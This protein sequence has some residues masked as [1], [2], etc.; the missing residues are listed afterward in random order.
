MQMVISIPAMLITQIIIA[1][2]LQLP[3]EYNFVLFALPLVFTVFA[4]FFGLYINLMFPNSIGFQKL[5]LSSRAQAYCLP[6]L[7][8]V[9]VVIPIV[10]YVFVLDKHGHFY[11]H[12]A[13]YCHI[14]YSLAYAVSLY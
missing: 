6:C 3:L 13:V 7:V 14:W 11:I 4:A 2:A 10:L 5:W 8:Y 1:F 9:A 12:T